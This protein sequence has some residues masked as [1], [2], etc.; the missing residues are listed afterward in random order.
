VSCNVSSLRQAITSAPDNAT[1]VLRPGCTYRLTSALPDVERNLTIQGRGATITRLSGSFTM[2]TDRGFN[3][4]L[5]R[6]AMTRGSRTAGASGAV[7]ARSGSHLTVTRS[8][9]RDDHGDVGGAVSLDHSSAVIA[10][11]AFAGNHSG[12][13]GGAVVLAN[14]SAATVR[15]SAFSGNTAE[16]AGGAIDNVDG[17]LTVTRSTFT[18]NSAHGYGGAIVSPGLFLSVANSAFTRNSGLAGGAIY[19]D[20]TA[21]TFAD[22]RFIANTATDG[23]GAVVTLGSLNLVR[24]LVSGNHA[25]GKGGGLFVIHQL[26]TLS[27]SRVTYNSADVSGGGIQAA[28]PG[29]VSLTDGSVV[30]HNRPDNCVNASC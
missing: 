14:G 12:G 10:D 22:S 20:G 3:L 15:N 9:F 24:D 25:D 17:V 7:L 18:G 19:S 4:T 21:T 5:N 13:Y 30:A 23:G 11:S 2:L 8:A 29:V 28:E 26:T 6:I 1:L 27:A 16:A